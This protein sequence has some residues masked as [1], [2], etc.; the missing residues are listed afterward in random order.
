MNGGLPKLKRRAFQMSR[1]KKKKTH[2]LEALWSERRK[3]KKSK[4]VLSQDLP[5]KASPQRPK[6]LLMLN[7]LKA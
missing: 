4:R 1:R 2:H 5:L 3:K 6:L 7:N